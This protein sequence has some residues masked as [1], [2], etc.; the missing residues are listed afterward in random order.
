MTR[1]L[2]YLASLAGYWGGIILHRIRTTD[3]KE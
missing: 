3:H 2:A 1:L